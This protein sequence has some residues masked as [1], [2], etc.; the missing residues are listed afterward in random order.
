MKHALEELRGLVNEGELATGGH[1]LR[2]LELISHQ[3]AIKDIY[4]NIFKCSQSFLLVG[5]EKMPEE[6]Q[7]MLKYQRK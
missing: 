2:D 7:W 1:L 5:R 4:K 6:M 3:I